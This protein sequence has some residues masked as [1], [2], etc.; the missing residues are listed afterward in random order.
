MNESL[1]VIDFHIELIVSI[2]TTFM[3][4][5]GYVILVLPLVR[6]SML[7][8][9][10]SVRHCWKPVSSVNPPGSLFIKPYH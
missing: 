3:A 8:L 2:K 6:P 4:Y 5:Y 10:T 9:Y 7:L 1:Q